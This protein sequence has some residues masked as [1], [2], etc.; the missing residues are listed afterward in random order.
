MKFRLGALFLLAANPALAHA[1]LEHATPAAGA[2]VSPAPKEIVLEFSESL[3]PAFSGA[4][5]RNSSGAS[6]GGAAVAQGNTMSVP[7]NTRAAGNYTVSWHAVSI[8]THRTQ[9][10]YRFTVTP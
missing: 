8:D 9:G 7:L 4:E 2:N 10:A 1:M 5:V 3:E 6:V